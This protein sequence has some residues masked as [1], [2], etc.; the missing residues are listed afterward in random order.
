MI[1]LKRGQ[2]AKQTGVNPETI[3]YYENIGLLPKAART[4]NGYRIYSEEDIRRIKFIKRAKE[5]GFTLKEIKELLE[6]RFEDIGSC[7]DVRELAEEKLKDVEQK[8]KDLEKIKKILKQLIDQCPGKGSI[9]QC[10][11]V[12]T[13]EE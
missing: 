9:S 6:L 5:L 11:I 3:R 1:G 4:E 7:S 10:P 13:I 2:L 12:S 8:I